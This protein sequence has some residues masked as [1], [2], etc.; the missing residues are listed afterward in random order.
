VSLV[1]LMDLRAQVSLELLLEQQQFL[2]DESM[3][4]QVRIIN[5]SGQTLRLGQDPDWLTFIVEQRDGHPVLR[6]GEV[7]VQG[8]FE[9]ESAT[10]ADRKFD[11]MPYFDLSIPGRYRLS[12]FIKIKDWGVTVASEPREFDI[13]RGAKVW[14]EEFGVPAPGGLPE[15]RKYILQ[16]AMHIRQLRLYARVTDPTEQRCFRVVSLGPLTSF[17]RFEAQIDKAS[18]LHVLFQTGA[19][20]FAYTV[21]DP[22][23]TVLMRQTYLY[24]AS[25]PRLQLDPQA[26]IVVAGGIRQPSPDDFPPSLPAVP[27]AENP[28]TNAALTNLVTP[29]PRPPAPQL[30]NPTNPPPTQ[31]RKAKTA[32][33]PRLQD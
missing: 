23:G 32:R 2:R 15:V 26:K 5:R 18:N 21:L 9:V 19:R 17:S 28:S 31:P 1:G 8:P 11:L 24:G 7:P 12:A 22:D 20:A 10:V 13:V 3:L 4:V 33:P 30:M 6:L 25:R 27:P 29:Q 16:R 14:E